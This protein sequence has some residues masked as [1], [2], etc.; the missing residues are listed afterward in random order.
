MK[1]NSP[2]IRQISTLERVK[3]RTSSRMSDFITDQI[4]NGE[5]LT[6]EKINLALKVLKNQCLSWNDFEDTTLG[7]I[8]LYSKEKNNCATVQLSNCVW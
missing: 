1:K 5:Q 6:D 2:L 4:L 7:P 3:C 8:R